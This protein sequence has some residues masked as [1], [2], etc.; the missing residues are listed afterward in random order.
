LGR[1]LLPILL[2]LHHHPNL[3]T[4]ISEPSQKDCLPWIRASFEV[5]CIEMD[6]ETKSFCRK[7]FLLAFHI[8]L[9]SCFRLVFLSPIVSSLPK[10][11]F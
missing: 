4:L 10:S 2:T 5:V 8:D 1:L 11:F 9:K 3:L 7:S 6:L